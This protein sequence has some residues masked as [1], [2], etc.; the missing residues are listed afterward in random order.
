MSK[1]FNDLK[2]EYK[3]IFTS[4]ELTDMQTKWENWKLKNSVTTIP[5]T[6]EQLILADIPDLVNI[7]DRFRNLPIPLTVIDSKGKNI[8]NPQFDS[9]DKIFKYK[10]KYDKK[11]AN[12]FIEH[13]KDL[14]ISTCH[15]CELA[16][17]NTYQIISG[18]RAI[19][20]Q[21]FDIDHYLPKSLC[22]IL[23]VSMFNFVPSCQVCNSRIK[24]SK[25]IGDKKSEWLEFSPTSENYS[26]DQDVKIRLRM[27]RGPDTTFRK[28]HEYYIYFRCKNGFRKL[29]DFFHL[30]ER[31]EFH[32]IEALR[33]R[34]LKTRY[35]KSARHKIASLLDIKEAQVKEDLFHE[36]YL[37]KN[38]R[39]FSKLTRDMLS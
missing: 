25:V 23:G 33:I 35:P 15:Y 19:M 3:N 12:F 27:H 37:K 4:A 34:S 24:L 38:K 18:H 32:K 10:K 2:T 21:H 16:Y 39:C 13:A 9:L 30:E 17:V 1:D 11:I 36:K 26:F 5:E 29:I 6:V 31:Y 8:R 20:Y 14:G 28:K 7:Y 22:P